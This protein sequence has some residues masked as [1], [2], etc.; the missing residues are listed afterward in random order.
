MLERLPC[1][2]DLLIGYAFL[3]QIFNT[4]D[5]LKTTRVTHLFLGLS[6]NFDELKIGNKSLF[7]DVFEKVSCN[8]FYI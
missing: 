8:Q 7:W 3:F 4:T 1:D 5:N 2:C 6:K